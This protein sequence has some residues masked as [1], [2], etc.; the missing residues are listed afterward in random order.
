MMENDRCKKWTN[1]RIA[2][3][4]DAIFLL[5]LVEFLADM[6]TTLCSTQIIVKYICVQKASGKDYGFERYA[7]MPELVQF[8]QTTMSDVFVT[9]IICSLSSLFSMHLRGIDWS[10]S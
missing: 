9:Y 10:D 5:L 6:F 4:Q 7:T 1:R 2:V 3:R 8:R